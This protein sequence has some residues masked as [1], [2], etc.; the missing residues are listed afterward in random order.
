MQIKSPTGLVFACSDA[1]AVTSIEVDPIRISM[2]SA[3]LFSRAGANL[4]LRRRGS[5]AAYVPLLGPH[6]PSRFSAT[7]DSFEAR[8]HWEGLEYTCV[9]QLASS[10]H[11]WRWRVQIENRSD[12]ALRLDL[13][14]VQDVGLHGNAAG[15]VNEQ[16]VSQYLERRVFDD[17]RHGCVVACRQNMRESVGYPWL[18]IAG[19]ERAVAAST[20][21]SQFYGTT[22]RATAEPEALRAERLGGELAGEASVVAL[23]SEP[24]VVPAG[25][26]HTC[27]FVATYTHDHPQASSE[28]DLEQLPEL[29]RAFAGDSPLM[30]A[31]SFRAPPR[32]RFQNARLLPAEDLTQAELHELFGSAWRH[33]EQA[34]SPTARAT[35]CCVR[36][37]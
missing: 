2:R 22:F 11:A 19:T 23:Q 16:Y 6:G 32:G 20:D 24:F 34:S 28:A 29:M 15:L 17:P 9:L 7:S 33:V 13:I 21:G 18:M 4:Y 30:A 10:Q 26:S 14:Y 12:R 5:D 1:G 27:A 37:R 35:W 3:S 31:S 8:G 25:Q 36:R